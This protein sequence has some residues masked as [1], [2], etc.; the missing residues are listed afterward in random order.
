MRVYLFYCS[1]GVFIKNMFEC[2]ICGMQCKSGRSYLSHMKCRHKLTPKEVYDRF[3]KKE[4]EGFCSICNRPTKFMNLKYGYRQYCCAKCAA[5]SSS[6]K[7]KRAKTNLAKYGVVNVSQNSDIKEIKAKKY[8]QQREYLVEKVKQTC[9]Q[10][11]GVESY[12]QSDEFKQKSKETH[13]KKYGVDNIVKTQQYIDKSN[14]TRLKHIQYMSEQGYIPIQELLVK[15][16]TGWYQ[17]NIVTNTKTYKHKKYI[18]ESELHTIQQYCCRNTNISKFHKSIIDFLNK[19]NIK[20]LINTRSIIKPFELDIYIPKHN[21]AIECDG[22]YWH[23]TNTGTDI[24]Y[25]ITKTTWCKQ[26]NI[27]LIHITEADWLFYEEVCKSLILKSIGFY[28]Y[29][30]DIECC[31]IVELQYDDSVYNFILNNSLYKYFE[32]KYNYTIYGIFYQSKLVQVIVFENANDNATTIKYIATL[33]Y[34]NIQSNHFTNSITYIA[35]YY[36]KNNAS[37]ANL[38]LHIDASICNI[39]TYINSN[40]FTYITTAK[41]DYALYNIDNTNHALKYIPSY[42]IKDKAELNNY[43]KKDKMLQVYDCGNHVL[44]YN[45]IERK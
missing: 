35:Q 41:P 16:G 12:T 27:H 1:E 30:I 42:A 4:N 38:Y 2:N 18:H 39:D 11:Y 32:Y 17:S 40:E 25:H 19:Y 36:L 29:N 3:Y 24:D 44:K 37:I 23:S 15:Y 20:T 5:N 28:K 10:K 45:K 22:I 9:L 8:E 31:N 43:I 7:E 13:L 26:Y 6:T 33:L 21:V 14:E 34:T